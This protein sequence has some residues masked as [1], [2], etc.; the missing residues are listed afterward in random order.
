VLAGFAP[1]GF[2]FLYRRE[3]ENLMTRIN[4]S[5]LARFRRSLITVSAL[6]VATLTVLTVPLPAQEDSKPKGYPQDWSH[7][8]VVFSN[9]GTYEDAVRNGTVDK[10][11]QITNDTRY[12]IQQ[13]ARS[14]SSAPQPDAGWSSNSEEKS[15]NPEKKKKKIKKDWS[16]G[17]GGLAATLKGTVGSLS[18]GTISGSSTLLVD[19]TTLDASPPTAASATGTFSGNPTNGQTVTIGGSEVL[20]AS[21]STAATASITVGSSFC[22]APGQGVDV[23]GTTLTTNATA[24]TGTYVVTAVPAAGVTVVIGGVTY[25]FETTLPSGSTP[26]N[27]VLVPGTNNSGNR[28][29]TAENLSVAINNSGTCG[30]TSGGVCTK[31]VSAANPEV[32]STDNSSATQTMTSLCA[33]NAAITNT[34][35]TGVTVNNVAAASSAGTNSTTTFALNTTGSTTTPA[36]QTL[37]AQNIEAAVNA[38]AT[39]SGIVTAT[40]PSTGVVTLTAKTWGTAANSYTL[41]DTATSG[42]TLGGFSGG[43]AGTNTGTSFAIDNVNGDNATNLAAA[44]TRNGGTVGV[45]A[46]A[47]GAVVTVTATTLGTGGNSIT[48]A[49]GLSNFTWSGSDLGGATDGTN[50]TTTFAY[51][52]GNNYLTSAQVATNIANAVNSNTTLQGQVSAIDNVPASGNVTFTAANTGANTYPITPSSF[53]AFTGG[54]LSG[55]TA[56]PNGTVQPN[57]YPAKYSFD[58]TTASCE[59]DFVVYPTGT[60][61]STTQASIAAYNGIYSGCTG[62]V[63]SVFWTYSTGG[64]VSTSPVLSL[65]GT[66]VA[67]IQETSG[68]IA[69]LVVLKWAA[70]T[71]GSLTAQ[72]SGAAYQ[73][74]TAPCF[75]AMTFGD[76]HD[77]TLS[78]PFYDYKHDV[79][80]VGDDSGDL[81]EFT[82]VFNGAPAENT[83]SPWPVALGSNKATSPVLDPAVPGV[84]PLIYVCDLAGVVYQVTPSTGAVT[85]TTPV[86]GG[87]IVDAPLIDSGANYLLVFVNTSSANSV[88]GYGEQFF[89]SGKGS[90][91]VGTGAAGHYLYAGTFDNSYF[92]SLDHD[93]YMY[94]IGNTGVTTGASLYRVGVINNTGGGAE[95][96]GV[97]TAVITGLTPSSSGAYPWPSPV[98]EFCNNGGSACALQTYSTCNTTSGSMT[99]TCTGAAFTTAEVGTWIEGTN[100][101]AQA[102]ITARGSATSITISAAATGTISNNTGAVT[103]GLTTSGIDY[104][105]F[106]VNRGNVGGCSTTAGDGCVLAYNVSNPEAVVISGTGLNT[107]SGTPTG[108]GCWAT[109]GI[110]IDNSTTAPTGASE[111]YTVNLHGNA[112]GNP[113][114]ATSS[115]CA[116]TSGSPILDGVQAS[117]ASP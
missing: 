67:F 23:N 60:A 18:S 26:A 69:S 110:V 7:R 58:T 50:S 64:E 34:G 105:F 68:G 12:K 30:S 51:W 42:V 77:D 72:A 37:T 90:A 85:S 31:N 113:L 39:T 29:I 16:T 100:I 94:V 115:V 49:E 1:L 75:Y 25:T 44:I 106:S 86:S 103:V 10:W 98:S 117:Q 14:G 62:A 71:S 28:T 70:G 22:F 9:P 66:Q 87:Q 47:A 56:S 20:T 24:G 102:T 59:N 79:L 65:D 15:P 19:T 4:R 3:S 108:N 54:S 57:A 116:A 45:S 81:H 104:I 40:N 99:V 114:G 46:N 89:P 74:C 109:G 97:S 88:Y 13:R 48:L 96:S 80:Y 78:S 112:A 73:T 2:C 83:T 8:H 61:T 111:I 84:G 33:D 95:L 63:P 53:S 82:G 11:T 21:L 101:P 91:A 93:G 38:N 55:G 35:V 92:Q 6:A 36:S 5:G 107:A 32:S 76:S 17:L 43:V 52:S 27:A 41:S